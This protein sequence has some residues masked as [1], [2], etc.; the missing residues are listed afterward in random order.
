MPGLPGPRGSCARQPRRLSVVVWDCPLCLSPAAGAPSLAQG[1]FYACALSNIY[2]FG[3]TFRAEMSFTTRHLAEFWMIEPEIAFCDLQDDMQCAE[4]YVRFCCQFLLDNC[5]QD[6]EFI[7]KM[8][9]KQALERLE[10]VGG[11][12]RG[13]GRGGWGPRRGGGGAMERASAGCAASRAGRPAAWQEARR[14]RL[15]TLPPPLPQVASSPFKRCSY[16]EAIELLEKA[17]AGGKKFDYPVSGQVGGPG[18]GGRRAVC[19]AAVRRPPPPGSISR[20]A[21][22]WGSWPCLPSS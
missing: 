11:G 20:C 10:Q 14:C 3:P 7:V 16:T 9:D 4:D 5:R 8:V 21:T 18:G 15:A 19:V 22:Q 13:T 1:E 12:W 17:V 6:L 2:T